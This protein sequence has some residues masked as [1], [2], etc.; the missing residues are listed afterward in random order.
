MPAIR[1]KHG[2]SRLDARYGGRAGW[3]GPRPSSFPSFDRKADDSKKRLHPG[4]TPNVVANVGNPRRDSRALR[5]ASG[6][7]DGLAVQLGEAPAVAIDLV[8]LP[9][10]DGRFEPWLSEL[11]QFATVVI[12]ASPTVMGSYAGLLKI[13]LDGLPEAALLDKTGIPLMIA[14][15]AR[16]AMAADIHLRPALLEMGA[17]CPTPSLVALESELASLGSDGL[18]TAWLERSGSWLAGITA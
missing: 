16:H 5:L 9:L 2:T 1:L 4:F 7:A 15:Q 18:V 6:I 14:R 17:S 8:D 11:V 13:F 12:A 10:Q 3:F